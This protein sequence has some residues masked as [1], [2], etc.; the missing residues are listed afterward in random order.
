MNMEF[1]LSQKGEAYEGRTVGLLN[2]RTVQLTNLYRTKGTKLQTRKKSLIR[3]FL[4]NFRK[5]I[6]SNL[7]E[8]SYP[9]YVN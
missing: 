8:I 5:L 4:T 1:I 9:D 3:L 2:Q 7:Y 6:Y